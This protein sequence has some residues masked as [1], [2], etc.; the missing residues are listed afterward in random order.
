MTAMLNAHG[1]TVYIIMATMMVVPL[2]IFCTWYFSGASVLKG[3]KISI[4]FTLFGAFMT[5][6]CGL[7]I[8]RKMGLA[9]MLIVP[10]VWAAPSWVLYRARNW[11]LAEPLSLKWLVGLQSFRLIGAVFIIE[12][13]RGNLPGIFAYP[14]GVGD[15]LTGL[16][17]IFILFQ[18]LENTKSIRLIRF[19]ILFG[20]ADFLIAFL[21]GFFSSESPVQIFSKGQPNP[22]LLFPTGLIPLFLV[23][24]AI[25]FHTLSELSL[26]IHH[27]KK[28]VL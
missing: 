20:M 19:L 22:L 6:V 3:L 14:A 28:A 13:A 24:V 8:P 7:E 26:K 25:F 9:G 15:M 11:F 23:P 16:L 21:T 2:Y 10:F 17:A 18:D 12:M 4:F 5:M 27:S 1:L